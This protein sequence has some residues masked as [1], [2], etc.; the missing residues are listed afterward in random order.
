[1]NDTAQNGLR[2]IYFSCLITSIASGNDTESMAA[3]AVGIDETVLRIMIL[4]PLGDLTWMSRERPGMCGASGRH[5]ASSALQF[6]RWAKNN[7]SEVR[8][9]LYDTEFTKLAFPLVP[10]GTS[11]VSIGCE[12]SY[13]NLKPSPPTVSYTTSSSSSYHIQCRV[14]NARNGQVKA[15]I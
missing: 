7:T 10:S 11:R 6:S 15:S 1:M 12:G 14:T 3:L 8:E 2:G 4:R 5:F 9:R 13:S